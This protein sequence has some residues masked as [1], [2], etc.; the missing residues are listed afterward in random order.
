MNALPSLVA[1]G[2]V[3]SAACHA[4]RCPDPNLQRAAIG[5]DTIDGYVSLHQKPLKSAQVRLLSNGKTTWVGSTNDV[6]SFQIKGL[7]P[8]TY[9]LTVK[10]WGNATI[11]ISP[12]L[13]KSFGNGQMLFYSLLLVDNE[14]IATI[15][16]TN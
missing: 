11:R 4:Q 8:G 10:G 5:G 9:R 16:V 14:C 1:I 15:T 3:L 2:I 6:G 12:D 7:R 13:T